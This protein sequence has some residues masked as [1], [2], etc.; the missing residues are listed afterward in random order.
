MEDSESW[1]NEHNRYIVL[2]DNYSRGEFVLHPLSTIASDG[3]QR[4]SLLV[5]KENLTLSKKT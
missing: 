1:F 3:E 5:I 4:R 2:F